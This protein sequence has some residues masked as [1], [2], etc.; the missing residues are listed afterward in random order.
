MKEAFKQI[1]AIAYGEV[2]HINNQAR[3]L[4]IIEVAEEALKTEESK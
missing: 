4:H 2:K 1:L 3:L